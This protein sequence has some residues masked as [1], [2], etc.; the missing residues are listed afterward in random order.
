MNNQIKY[1]LFIIVILLACEHEES[2]TKCPPY[3][4]V[5]SSP[6][7]DPIWH[8]SCEIVG[9]NHIPI[10][11]IHYSNG[12]DCPHQA[13]YIYEVD[14]VGFWLINS[15]GT[16]R[17]MILPYTL[18]TPSWSPDGKWIAFSEGAQICIMPFDGYQ[19]DTTA[20][21]QLTNEGRNFYPT[22]SP[23]GKWIAFD[24]NA[25]TESGAYFIWKVKIDGSE[26]KRIIYTPSQGSA[27]MPFWGKDFAILYQKYLVKG[28]PEIFRMDSAG[29]NISQLTNNDLM[30]ENPQ[31]SPDG[32]YFSY[33]SNS[34][35]KL[36]LVNMDTNDSIL[37]VEGCT[38]YSWSPNGKI[39][40]VNYDYS[41]I[42]EE[43]GTLWIMD[44][45]GANN[46]QLTK[47]IFKIIQ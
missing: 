34:G 7:N 21:V 19:F 32:L 31:F 13:T 11:E 2:K 35:M 16:N 46:K 18:V 27:R 20:I 8:P 37:A 3:D 29:S 24:S 10:K 40:Y 28:T 47:N 42:D 14:S 25:E 5:P 36:W 15:D 12:Y 33:I 17:R 30:E 9:F 1:I 6:Y 23:D 26:K 38:N 39:V 44:S 22:W 43:K 41:R 4:I 45:D